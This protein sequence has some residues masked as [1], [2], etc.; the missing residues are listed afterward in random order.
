MNA[1]ASAG[2]ETVALDQE[3]ER[4]LRER[5][6]TQA[7]SYDFFVAV[8][9]L[10]RATPN[11][12]RIGGDG[13]PDGESIR[14]RHDPSLAFSSGDITGVEYVEV[15][16]GPH[17]ALEKRRHRYHVT[18]SFLGLTGSASPMPLFMS[19]ELL[20]AQESGALRRD[21][22]DLFHHRL[23]SLVY[24]IG[25]KFDVPREFTTDCNDAWTMRMLALAGLDAFSGRRTKHVPMWRMARIAPLLA[26]RVRSAH[27]IER[28]LQD[29]CSEAL[30]DAVVEMVQFAGGWSPIDPEQRTTLGVLNS[31]LGHSSV[32]GVQCFDRAGKDVVQVPDS[33]LQ[34]KG[35]RDY[36]KATMMAPEGA[37]LS[38]PIDLNREHHELQRPFVPTF[39]VAAPLFSPRGRRAGIVIINADMRAPLAEILSMADSGRVLMLARGDGEVLL[40]PDT[41]L[42]FRFELGG[43][44]KLRESGLSLFT[45]VDFAGH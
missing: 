3:T 9:M 43:S 42:T 1:S 5:V 11:A 38:F 8:G 28:A 41:S 24:R 36:Y 15:P 34:A 26:S 23:L 35:D 37:R 7:S 10:E 22:L 19:E 31:R 44:K 18:T 25:I 12:V 29:V 2:R 39:R 14:F 13:P 30:G 4:A 16:R 20:Q 33:L 32:L 40:H 45:L 17:Q 6:L 27:V 21:F